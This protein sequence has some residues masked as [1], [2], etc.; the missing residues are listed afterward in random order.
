MRVEPKSRVRWITH[1]EA[2][3]LLVAL[4]APLALAAEFSLATGL[5]QA[6]VLG[7]QWAQLDLE[8]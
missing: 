1:E 6:N 3:N 4:P 8:R 7:L 2:T 5:R